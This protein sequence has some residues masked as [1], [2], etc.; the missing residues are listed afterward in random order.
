VSE[1][2]RE[3]GSDNLDPVRCGWLVGAADGTE[4]EGINS[5]DETMTARHAPAP[6]V[7][8]ARLDERMPG[9]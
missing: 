6:V 4:S 2:G 3:R 9:D 5:E 1:C 7:P 8:P